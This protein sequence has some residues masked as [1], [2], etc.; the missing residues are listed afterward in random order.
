MECIAIGEPVRYPIKCSTMSRIETD[1][2]SLQDDLPPEIQR[3]LQ[4]EELW[5]RRTV[6]A[7]LMNSERLDAFKQRCAAL[8]ASSGDVASRAKPAKPAATVVQMR[9]R[10]VLELAAR[11]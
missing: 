10:K 1:Q 3:R 8:A 7:E 4:V 2:I 5:A 6:L 9:I 11:G